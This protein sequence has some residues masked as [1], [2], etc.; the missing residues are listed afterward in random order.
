MKMIKKICKV[1]FQAFL[2]LMLGFAVILT[3]CKKEELIGTHGPLHYILVYNGAPRN[4]TSFKYSLKIPKNGAEIYLQP[5]SKSENTNSLIGFTEVSVNGVLDK[6]FD[7]EWDKYFDQSMDGVSLSGE[8]G[9]VSF[10]LLDNNEYLT[11]LEISPNNTG[12]KRVIYFDMG[13]GIRKSSLY[14]TQDY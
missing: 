10:K 5:L 3:A 4:V 7:T 1:P 12:A 9:V 6:E 2:I 11:T 13:L 8:W 14:I